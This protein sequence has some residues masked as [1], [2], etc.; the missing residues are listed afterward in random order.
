MTKRSFSGDENIKFNQ[1]KLKYKIENM[2]RDLIIEFK[3]LIGFTF[4]HILPEKVYNIIIEY[5][6]RSYLLNGFI[7]PDQNLIDL[8]QVEKNQIEQ[9]IAHKKSKNE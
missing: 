9:S 1:I 7:N 5:D 4:T 8:I 3:D 6:I 2:N